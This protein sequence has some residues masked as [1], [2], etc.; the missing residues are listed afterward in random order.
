[1]MK[2][3]EETSGIGELMLDG[4]VLQRVPY[5]VARVQGMME[6]SVRPIPGVQRIEGSVEFQSGPDPHEWIALPLALRLE[7][8]RV[9]GV[10]LSNAE[11]RIL[12]EGHGPTKCLCC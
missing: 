5:R 2:L 10:T 3:V 4:I 12:S 8:G 1:M 9:L 11:G 6:G 7:D